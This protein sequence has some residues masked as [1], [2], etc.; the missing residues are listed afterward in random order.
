MLRDPGFLLALAAAPVALLALEATAPWW[1]AGVHWSWALMLALTVWHPI[2]E[3]LLFRGAIQGQLLRHLWARVEWAG[4]SVANLATSAAFAL[5]HLLYYAAPWAVAVF[6]PS[7]VFGHFR[8]RHRSVY[9]GIVLHAAY[10]G[11]FLAAAAYF[12]GVAGR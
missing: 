3:E 6:L 2:V 11:C 9:P 12:N 4:L 5:A 7:L 8:D 1:R 10:N